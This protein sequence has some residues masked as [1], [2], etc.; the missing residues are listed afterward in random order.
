MGARIVNNCSAA[1]LS[2]YLLYVMKVNGDD[3]TGSK[4]SIYLAIYPL[5]SFSS[6]VAIS[7]YM[8]ELYKWIGRKQTFSIGLA[9]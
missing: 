9:T 8:G 7:S 4:N 1:M 2:F 5:I 6:S 3:K